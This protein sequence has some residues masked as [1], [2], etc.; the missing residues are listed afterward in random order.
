MG[1]YFRPFSRRTKPVSKDAIATLDAIK[2][3]T[4]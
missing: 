3:S 4:P 2:A 1:I